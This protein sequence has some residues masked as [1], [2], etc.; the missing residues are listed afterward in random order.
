MPDRRTSDSLNSS[1]RPRCKLSMQA[2]ASIVQRLQH[3]GQRGGA[4][5]AAA[6]SW[7][8]EASA[9]THS[10]RSASALPSANVVMP[11]AGGTESSSLRSASARRKKWQYSAWKS[12]LGA[13]SFCTAPCTT[14]REQAVRCQAC[15]DGLDPAGCCSLGQSAKLDPALQAARRPDGVRISTCMLA[16][17]QGSA[18][19]GPLPGMRK[20]WR[21]TRVATAYGHAQQAGRSTWSRPSSRS[22]M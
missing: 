16:M 2:G 18:V 19:S 10:S 5:M 3:A 14:A 7:Y 4:P 22:L 21:C 8:T 6:C 13:G 17:H 11:G 15:R 9:R 12:S 20:Q 1:V